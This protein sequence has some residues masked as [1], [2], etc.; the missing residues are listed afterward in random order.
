MQPTDISAS[1]ADLTRLLSNAQA[2]DAS[3]AAKLL[4]VVYA[5][6]RAIAQQRMSGERVGHTL[7]A[8][9][10]VHEAYMRLLGDQDIQWSNRAHFFHAAAEAMRR[11]LI[12]YA[13]SRG[14][15]KRGGDGQGRPRQ[16]V[17]LDVVDLAAEADPDEILSLD[18]AVRRL[19]SRD[20]DLGRIVRLRFFAGLNEQETAEALGVTDRTIRRDWALAKALLLKDLAGDR[21]D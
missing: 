14:R 9:A 11:I 17:S 20:P 10:L 16:R 7:E 8:T 19:E 12:E 1:Q 5:Q 3:A 21:V 13:R 2:A 4:D 6:L 18:E 15:K